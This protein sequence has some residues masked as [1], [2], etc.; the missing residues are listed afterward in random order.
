MGEKPSFLVLRRFETGKAQASHSLIRA[1]TGNYMRFAK[2]C[3]ARSVSVLVSAC[4]KAVQKVMGGNGA[5]PQSRGPSGFPGNPGDPPHLPQLCDTAS[6]TGSGSGTCKR[7]YP[8][9]R[10][11]GQADHGRQDGQSRRGDGSQSRGGSVRTNAPLC[12]TDRAPKCSG[13]LSAARRSTSTPPVPDAFRRLPSCPGRLGF[14]DLSDQMVYE[15]I[16]LP[17]SVC[18]CLGLGET[19]WQYAEA[20]CEVLS[21]NGI[22]CRLEGV[23][24]G[25]KGYVELCEYEQW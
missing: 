11:G 10:G 12:R 21:E 4:A 5:G 22:T 6:D 17:E 20:F 2:D 9:A 15:M 13:N 1:E 8:D 25:N 18:I 23:L 3:G 24:S 19:T 16:A 7:G 14:R